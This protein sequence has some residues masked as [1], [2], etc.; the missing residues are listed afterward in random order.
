[1][2]PAGCIQRPSHCAAGIEG[3]L[4]YRVRVARLWGLRHDWRRR[5]AAASVVGAGQRGTGPRGASVARRDRTPASFW[6]AWRSRLEQISRTMMAGGTMAGSTMARNHGSE[7]RG[8]GISRQRFPN[9]VGAVMSDLLVPANA[10]AAR[11]R[12]KRVLR[13][14]R[15][16]RHDRGASAAR[17]MKFFDC[18]PQGV[19]PIGGRRPPRRA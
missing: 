15:R 9:D 4:R 7:R 13:R 18:A 11:K 2:P 6:E 10:G 14:G 3:T 5:V 8:G 1:M 12:E 19:Y 17:P 16:N